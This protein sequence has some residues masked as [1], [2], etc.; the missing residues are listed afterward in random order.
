MFYFQSSIQKQREG[1]A[2][3]RW[4]SLLLITLVLLAGCTSNGGD[5]D[6]N[7]DSDT[8]TSIDPLEILT[9]A[10]DNIRAADTFRL[11]VLHSGAD[12]FA[13]IRLDPSTDI[14]LQVAFRRAVAQYVAPNE[15]QARVR[16]FGGTAIEVDVYAMGAEQW[17]RFSGLDWIQEEFAEG[18]NPEVLIAE[19][20]GFEAALSALNELHYVGEATLD[21][22]DDVY[23]ITGTAEGIN[24]SALLVGLIDIEG[25]VTVDVF[26]SRD[27]PRYPLRLVI[28]QNDT[29]T[30]QSPDPT[31]WTIELYDINAESEIDRPQR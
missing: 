12:Y 21:T 6:G 3:L 19:D 9:E 11:D 31:T 8:Q 26:I 27:E 4:I 10:S 18:F 28:V 20:T 17:I 15:L 1:N 7:D 23:H 16:V 5:D 2:V 29:V 24:V 25:L 13:N 22:G 30:E 14:S